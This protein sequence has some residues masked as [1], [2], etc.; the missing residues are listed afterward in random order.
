MG[1]PL[2]PLSYLELD[3]P[4]PATGWAAELDRRGIETV[5]D[6]IGR[7]CVD[8]S[9]ARDL[10][11]EHAADQVRKARHRAE[12]EQQAIE[13]DRRFRAALPRGVPAAAV[14]DGMSAGLLLMASDPMDQGR[15]RETV[16]QHALAHPDGALIYHPVNGEAS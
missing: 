11:A 3:C 13:C 12:V 14:P 6:D 2:I 4:A 16:L 10:L 7:V 1:E 15:R 5:V 9:D 8:R